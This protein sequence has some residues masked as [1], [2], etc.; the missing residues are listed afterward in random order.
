MSDGLRLQMV[1]GLDWSWNNQERG[2]MTAVLPVKGTLHVAVIEE[3]WFDLRPFR[4][5]ESMD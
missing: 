3:L 2:G 5:T 1:Y 4:Y